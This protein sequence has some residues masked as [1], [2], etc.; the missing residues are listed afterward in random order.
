[1][2]I[3]KQE[4]ILVRTPVCVYMCVHTYECAS[5]FNTL[6][7]WPWALD[8]LLTVSKAFYQPTAEL[9]SWAE[10]QTALGRRAKHGVCVN[11]TVSLHTP[12][13]L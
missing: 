6:Q 2:N 7:T 9:T 11:I 13:S 3:D 1:M 5:G 8:E 12:E 10:R 4:S